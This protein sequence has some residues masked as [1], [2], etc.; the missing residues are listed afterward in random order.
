[1]APFGSLHVRA[2]VE[3]PAQADDHAEAR[4]GLGRLLQQRRGDR[5]RG[6]SAALAPGR[7]RGQLLDR[8]LSAGASGGDGAVEAV[9]ARLARRADVQRDPRRHVD[10]QDR[11]EDRTGVGR[12]DPQ[13]G[14]LEQARDPEERSCRC[15]S[16]RIAG[17]D[18]RERSDVGKRRRLQREPV[19][20][21]AFAA[22]AAR[23]FE[24]AAVDDRQPF[25]LALRE[26]EL[27]LAG[28]VAAGEG[29]VSRV[30]DGFD[31]RG[32]RVREGRADLV[33]P[34]REQPDRLLADLDR[35]RRR[36]RRDGEG[37]GLVSEG[38]GRPV[39]EEHAGR[40]AGGDHH[41][42]ELGGGT[43]DV[44]HAPGGDAHGGGRRLG[45]ARRRGEPEQRGAREERPRPA[46]RDCPACCAHARRP[47]SRLRAGSVH[48]TQ[49]SSALLPVEPVTSPI[50]AV[51][52]GPRGPREVTR[53]GARRQ[54]ARSPP[55]FTR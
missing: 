10:G 48:A 16:V 4:D 7:L 53:P 40:D 36:R 54:A 9:E 15:G 5:V 52:S 17:A 11:A 39:L 23:Q 18:R 49:R 51:S 25:F 31:G 38:E 22:Q 12:Q 55:A 20:G 2:V 28:R 14:V 3:G 33:V 24:R 19:G 41:A 37:F 45:G 21:V 27:E 46:S 1:M 26:D 50:G 47:P 6:G 35:F 34:V 29:L 42:V 43:T 44:C 32:R 8:Q 13:L 30:A